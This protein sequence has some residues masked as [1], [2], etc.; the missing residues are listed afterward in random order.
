MHKIKY[1]SCKIASSIKYEMYNRKMYKRNMNKINQDNKQDD[2]I[3][4]LQKILILI[5]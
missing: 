3:K 1:D 5:V 2:R 4:I